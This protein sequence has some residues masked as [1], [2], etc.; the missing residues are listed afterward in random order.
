MKAT[1]KK[2]S[3]GFLNIGEKFILNYTGWILMTTGAFGLIFVILFD[4][5]AG[6]ITNIFG[7]VQV[8]GV[9]VSLSLVLF[10]ACVEKYHIE[11]KQI[12]DDY[13]RK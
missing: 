9:V 10:G 12:L 5:I 13:V 3:L 7:W 6:R 1:K 2:E 8:L 11:I 4:T